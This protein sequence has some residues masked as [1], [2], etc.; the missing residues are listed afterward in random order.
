MDPHLDEA[1]EADQ[2]GESPSLEEPA[3]AEALYLRTREQLL[4]QQ[5]QIPLSTYRVQLHKDFDFARAS[6]VVPYLARLGVSH[7]YTSPI[8]KAMPGS[9]HGY[10]V[11]DHTTVNPEL[12]GGVGFA[13]L[14]DTLHGNGMRLVLDTVPNHMGIASGNALWEDVLENGP[15]ALHSHFFDIEWD[16]VKSELRN[17]VLLPILG[18]QYGVVLD[19]GELQLEYQGGSF[20]L[21]YFDHRLPL[22]PR[23]YQD[24]L[25][26]GVEQVGSQ[27]GETHPDFVE[28]QSILTGLRNLPSRG[29]TSAEKVLERSREKEV[30]KRRLNTVVT[31]SPVIAEFLK[32]SL[33]RL[34]GTPNEPRSFD[35]LHRLLER[36]VPY[37]LA[38]WRVAGEEINYRRFFD[39]NTLAAVRVEDL[40]VFEEAHAL[41]FQFLARGQVQGLR[42]DHP[43]GL[44]DPS[45]Y[46]LRLQ[47]RYFLDQARKLAG[48]AVD[49]AGWATVS[50]AL[51]RRWRAEAG[52]DPSS[53]LRRA[54]YVVVEKIQGGKERI[55]DD[56]AIRG[57]TG[58][59]FANLTTGVLV[60]ASAAREF[61]DIY[62]KFIG[63]PMRFDTLL[64]EKKKQVMAV[65]MASEINGLARELNR[66]SEMNRRTRDFT[67]NSIRRA[68]IGF[69][70]HFPVY[71]TYVSGAP[72]V[73]ERDAHYIE[74]T[75]ARARMADPTTNASLFEWLEDVLLK[76]YPEH[77]PLAERQVMLHFAMKLQQITGP[78]MAKGLEDTVFYVY[79]RLVALNEVGGEPEHFGISVETFHQ[80]NVERARD[81]PGALVASSTHDTKRSQDVRARLV[82]LSELP[83]EWRRAL[84]SW[85][86]L[87]AV[88]KT[89]LAGTLAPSGNDEYLLYQT[90]LGAWPMGEMDPGQLPTFRA[91]IH[92]YML[93]AIREAKVHTSWTNPDPDYEEAT[94]RFVDRIV[95]PAVS[96]VFF[97]QARLLKERIERPGQVNSL[98]QVALKLASP[99]VPDIYQ[100]GEL[101]DLSL[102]DPD[103]RRPVDFQLREEMLSELLRQHGGA[104][105][106]VARDA[107]AHP[108]D[109]RCKLLITTMM[110]RLRQARPDLF[111]RGAYEP[112]E[113][114]GIAAG[115]ALAFARRLRDEAVVVAA[116]RLVTRALRAGLGPVYGSTRMRLPTDLAGRRFR[117]V[118][119]GVRVQPLEGGLALGPLFTDFPVA[120]LEAVE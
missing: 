7:L 36:Y 71:R 86:K 48:D 68:L 5:Q 74:W 97:E 17:K 113:L 102:V 16:P 54:L 73:D 2:T 76:R 72:G 95:D 87:N 55:P 66:I 92:E 6:A 13:A 84:E 40:D 78:V 79:N 14:T 96:R 23:A 104:P 90:L 80:R 82:V 119:T 111:R 25:G 27:L 42:I 30:L 58:Y 18:D 89:E 47:E 19:R 33:A 56:W 1:R 44:F 110:L 67:L 63:H 61:T 53:P 38:H 81:W 107:W 98:V 120:V 60:D 10:D 70:A 94:R 59:R 22:N 77:L 115:R 75:I 52:S 15:A 39:I 105:V 35:E 49:D 28:L 41:T 114:D 32:A 108:A 29:D 20:T 43:D 69:I 118:V 57:T 8:L 109:G 4:A 26:P 88:H 51:L 99:G 3:L 9:N 91:R 37:R 11:V 101:W 45:G 21:R 31:S 83:G 112:L 46:F 34:N 100:G 116:P 93:K 117:N 106:G 85:R 103:N 65:S 12:G 50:D 62:E 24:V 64:V